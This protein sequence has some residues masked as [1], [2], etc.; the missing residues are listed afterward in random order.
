MIWIAC[1]RAAV[2][3]VMERG[4][5]ALA[6]G[7][8]TEWRGGGGRFCADADGSICGGVGPGR[9]YGT[10]NVSETECP[11]FCHLPVGAIYAS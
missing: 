3:M 5:G 8:V 1:G 2:V 9:N 4:D 11:T 7:V 10:L 6:S